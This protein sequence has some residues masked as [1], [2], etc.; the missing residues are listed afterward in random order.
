M[1]SAESRNYNY[2]LQAVTYSMTEHGKTC[3]KKTSPRCDYSSFTSF[4]WTAFFQFSSEWRRLPKYQSTQCLALVPFLFSLC[5]CWLNLHGL[6]AKT[7][8]DVRF[9]HSTVLFVHF[10]SRLENTASVIEEVP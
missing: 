7:L 4:C 2:V 6:S 1:H 3:I 5:C 10:R 9:T 8:N